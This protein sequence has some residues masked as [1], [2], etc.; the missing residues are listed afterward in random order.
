MRLGEL[1][2]RAK[3]VEKPAKIEQMESGNYEITTAS[4]S[5]Y[6][7]AKADDGSWQIDFRGKKLSVESFSNWPV[8]LEQLA[9]RPPE[10]R[11]GHILKAD[12]EVGLHIIINDSNREVDSEFPGWTT[13][14][15]AT[16]AKI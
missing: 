14:K 1:F 16:I 3:P 10:A 7:L 9:Y 13:S 6:A 5:K 11:E 8:S 12:P 2:H 15:I 4:G